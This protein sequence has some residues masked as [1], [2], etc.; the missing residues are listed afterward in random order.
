MRPTIDYYFSFV[1]LWSYIGSD[2][3]QQLVERHDIEVAYKPI[4]LHAI[5][6]AGG[7]LPV[8]QRPP[9]RQAYRFVEMQRWRDI[10]GI[11]LVLKPKHAIITHRTALPLKLQT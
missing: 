4:D 7:G 3:F 2:A 8:T 5:F 6:K 1:S 9:Q 11:P 10:R